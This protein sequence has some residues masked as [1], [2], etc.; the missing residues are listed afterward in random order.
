MEGVTNVTPYN[1]TAEQS[2]IGSMLL[3]RECIGTVTQIVRSSDFYD[4]RNK[5]YFECIADLYNLDLPVDIITVSERLKKRGTFEKTGAEEYLVDVANCVSTSANVKHYCKI[6]AEYSVRRKLIS[7]SGEITEM[8]YGGNE[9]IDKILDLSSQKVFDIAL[10]RNNTEF[11]PIRDVLSSNFEK[12]AE[13]SKNPGKLVGVPTGFKKLDSILS[14]LNKA[15]FVLV[16]ARPAMGK[17]SFALNIATNAAL[18][19]N[20]KVAIFSLE[21]SKEEIVNR[22]WFSSA[23]VESNKIKTG[24]VQP[25]DWT[26]LINSMKLLSP[27]NIYIDDTS[28]IS[29]MDIRSKCRRLM[30]EQ[31]LDLIIIDHIQLMQGIRRS[32]NRQQEISEI[33]RSLK[34]LAKDFDIPVLALSQLSRAS[35]DRSDK[36]PLL[37][38]LR[39][40]G[41][42][43]QDADVVLM[44]YRDEYYNENTETPGQ[45]EVIIAKHRSGETGKV[46]LNWQ[47]EYTKFADF[48]YTHTES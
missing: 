34:M 2:I 13:L 33:S 32:E 47:S 15:N 23:I 7:V 29:V 30:M 10:K 6:V 8:A 38:D 36:R 17:T 5:E 35:K 31:G 16:A 48:D 45:A 22:I 41:A 25:A 1:E 9:D 14:G 21:M 26:R 24:E 44:L 27:A 46:F 39:E 37:T 18:T 4:P 40:S 12:L 11:M 43:E 3:D 28:S 19:A 42:I 20:K